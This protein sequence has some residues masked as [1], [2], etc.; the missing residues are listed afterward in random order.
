M[1]SGVVPL[2]ANCAAT[3]GVTWLVSRTFVMTFR[4]AP[5]G[6]PEA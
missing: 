4:S 6:N 3:P 5:A 1:L 2:P